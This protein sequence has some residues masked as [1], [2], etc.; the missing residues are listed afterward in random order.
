MEESVSDFKHQEGYLDPRLTVTDWGSLTSAPHN[1][2]SKSSDFDIRDDTTPQ[3]SYQGP[4][5]HRTFDEIMNEIEMEAQLSHTG[6]SHVEE[7]FEHQQSLGAMRSKSER[8]F[9][10]V[11]PNLAD[12]QTHAKSCRVYLPEKVSPDTPSEKQ[13]HCPR[14]D[15]TFE[16][17]RTVKHH[18]ARCITKHGNPDALKW[19]DHIS[20][21][22]SHE[23]GVSDQARKDNFNNR[24]DAYSGVKIP[25]KLR[26]GE[27]IVK[28]VSSNKN[29]RFSCAICGGGP[30]C[31]N[32]H[33][34]SHFL[35]CVKRY[36]NPTGAKWYDGSD[37][38]GIKELLP[39][40]PANFQPTA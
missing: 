7:D 16:A 25:S 26:P 40:R 20:L 32:T 3:V 21:Q 37:H 30:F 27:V 2:S 34:K 6:S 13:Y 10:Q 19:T 23:R 35:T 31:I 18:F 28:F 24:L 38:K 5:T 4:G 22:A 11:N 33:V 1:V 39:E 29:G 8:A 9:M 12:D 36:G 17:R 14:C 15:K